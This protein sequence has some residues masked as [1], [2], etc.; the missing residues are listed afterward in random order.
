M[1]AP[2]SQLF[3]GDGCFAAFEVRDSAL[4]VR[5]CFGEGLHGSGKPGHHSSQDVEFCGEPVDLFVGCVD[6]AP[7]VFAAGDGPGFFPQAA[8]EMGVEGYGRWVASTTAHERVAPGNALLNAL[9]ERQAT[10]WALPSEKRRYQR[11]RRRHRPGC[12]RSRGH[13]RTRGSAPPASRIRTLYK[14]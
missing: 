1:V 3:D 12:A 2:G 7:G 4:V 13:P 10:A 5:G 14:M 11:G 9:L 6:A 8:P